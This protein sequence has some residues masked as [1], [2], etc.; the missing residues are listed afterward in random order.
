MAVTGT[1]LT[2]AV[3]RDD[4]DISVAS[5]TGASAGKICKMETEYSVVLKVVG[6]IVSLRTR[7]DHGT[8]ATP[9]NIL[10]PVAFGDPSDFPAMPAARHRGQIEQIDGIVHYGASGPIA[11]PEKDTTVVLSGASVLAMT[12]PDPTRLQDGLKL[13][14]MSNGAAAHTVTSAT[15]LN[16]G[17][18][19]VDVATFAAAVG[20]NLSLE[21]S[22]GKW[23]VRSSVGVTLA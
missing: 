5:A 8:I 22:G 1:T 14:I 6:N 3:N 20:N 4:L 15:G 12:L 11:V 18:A 23:L 16:A 10:T 21:A 17:G 19:S 7:G 2:A 13:H 9:H